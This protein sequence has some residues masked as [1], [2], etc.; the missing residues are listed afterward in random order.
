ME[1]ILYYLW[2]KNKDKL[3]YLLSQ[4][5]EYF[6]LVFSSVQIRPSGSNHFIDLYVL[7]KSTNE[8]KNVAV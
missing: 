7:I 2:Y 4:G 6:V 8:R 5:W 3:L 1:Q